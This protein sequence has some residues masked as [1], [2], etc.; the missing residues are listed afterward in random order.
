MRDDAQP[1]LD[2]QAAWLKRYPAVQVRIEGNCDERGTREYNLALGARRANAVREYLVAHGVAAGRIDT[3]SYGKE[4]PIDPGAGEEAGAHNRNAHT[5]I[6]EGAPIGKDDATRPAHSRACL[7]LAA[8]SRRRRRP[9]R[10]TLARRSRSTRAPPSG[11]TGWRRSCG[12]CAPSSSRAA[13]PAS[14]WWSSRPTPT[15]QIAGPDRQARTTS[16]R[17]WRGSTASSRSS[18]TTSTRRARK[19]STCSGQ[20][21][22][23]Q[24][25]A[26]R[27]SNSSCAALTAAAAAAARRHA[28][29]TAAAAAPRRA[30]DPAGRLRRRQGML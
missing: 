24:G 23:L 3:V 9:S 13:R 26:G 11:S 27:R 14:R 12:S 2:A 17:P 16:S 21:E 5:A 7:G 18:A 30:A 19:P 4:Q 10:Q 6:T 25:A 29:P 1:V 20:I 15:A 22:A 28:A 8:V